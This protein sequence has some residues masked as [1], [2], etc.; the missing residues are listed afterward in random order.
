V[1]ETA[2][3]GAAGGPTGSEVLPRTDRH[4]ARLA[5][6]AIGLAMAALAGLGALQVGA[7]PT[8][9][10][11]GAVAIAAG[12]LALAAL[13][14]LPFAVPDDR[15]V[16]AYHGPAFVSDSQGRILVR[17][18]IAKAQFG[19]EPGGEVAGALAML[20]GGGSTE[21]RALL[22]AA[23]HHG[24]VRSD[25]R[26]GLGRR[27]VTVVRSARH[28]HLWLIDPMIQPR[29]DAAGNRLPEFVLDAEDGVVSA[30]APL[31]ELLGRPARRVGDI[32]AD[33]PL[34]PGAVHA[35]AGA[36]GAVLIVDDGIVRA[37]RRF[38]AVPCD[39]VAVGGSAMD[40][41]FDS[42]PVALVKLR[43]DGTITRANRMAR[44]LLGHSMNGS[45]R[46]D[47]LVEGLGRSV[48]GWLREAAAGQTF[49]SEVVRAVAPETDAYIQVTLHRMQD[50][51]QQG[52]IALLSDATELKKLEAQFVQS[53]KMQAI[54]QLAGGVAHDF[55]NLLTAISGHCDLLLLRHDEGDDDFAD[56]IQ[57]HQN[58]NRAASLVGQLLAF[59][60][61]QHLNPE[62]LDLR[63][64]L[65]DLGHLLNRLVGERVT[66]VHNHADDL[67][68]VR[69]DRRQLE[70][71]VMNLV[72]NA[73]DA[74]SGAGEIRIATHVRTQDHRVTRDRAEIPPG[75]Y[76]VISIADTGCGIP[77]D[78]IGKVFEPFF[79]T[80]RP[81]EGTG[82]GLSTAYGIVK[83]TG[84][85]IFIDSTP[86][87]GTTFEVLL[88]AAE[89]DATE[90][91]ED[92]AQTRLTARHGEG[93]VLLVEDEAPVRAFASRALQMRGYRVIVAESGEEALALLE[94]P[95]L[96]VDVFVTDVVM[97]GLDGPTWVRQALEQRPGV[98][99]VF[100]SGYAEE[101][102]HHGDASL[103]DAVFL[104]KPFSLNE[105]SATVL[106]QMG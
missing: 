100:I 54:G 65:S 66:L 21:A 105:L 55:N 50:G 6:A 2:S 56:L 8:D 62:R 5:T 74:M 88:P 10:V 41:F 49:R 104:A 85:F 84:G 60:R 33:P 98:R 68:P 73:R 34:R 71:V 4:G 52:L 58:A 92:A 102:L 15:L 35:L 95:G 53:Q 69:A 48:S 40:Q 18:D 36:P 82:L 25:L 44:A 79:T 22:V 7:P 91:P 93:V 39:A 90:A 30:N 32:V 26:T 1:R 59:S 12:L 89:A 46:F 17:N 67:P 76:A 94:D 37:G 64:T 51:D 57:I 19:A 20:S 70:Q 63:E 72:V 24:R 81:G 11:I 43:A 28:R 103:K 97:P 14:R 13:W 27:A 75:R 83:Q 106:R 47:S 38:I 3:P 78:R 23:A 99:V 86:G 29:S 45:P 61:K 9:L 31:A 101:A 96:E 77:A 16:D 42:L 80:K 87:K